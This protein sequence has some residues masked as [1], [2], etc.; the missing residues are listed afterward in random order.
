M[1]QGDVHI[2]DQFLHDIMTDG[3]HNLDSDNIYCALIDSVTTPAET[4][5]DPRWGTGG[6]TNLSTNEVT[7]TAGNYTA[8]GNQCA[9]PRRS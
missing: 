5:S 4:T 1:A 3:V 2:F 9:T 7:E 6:G 8:G